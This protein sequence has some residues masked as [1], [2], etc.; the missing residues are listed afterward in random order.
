M[1]QTSTIEWTDATWNPVRGCTKISPGCKHCYAETFAERFRGV[2]GHPYEQGFDL[3][4]VPGKLDEPL[5]WKR[6][7]KIFVN[8][9]SDLFHPNVPD[10]Y[11]EQVCRVMMSAHWH[12]YQVLTKRAGRLNKLLNS[13]LKFATESSH[14]WWGVSVENTK[15]GAPRINEL[16]QTPAA[17]KFLSVEPLLEDLGEVDLS[18][19]HWMIVGGESGRGARPMREE[20]V[21][22][23][24]KQC[25][26]Q[27]VRFFFKQWGGPNKKATGRMLNGRTYDELPI[28]Q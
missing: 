9:M 2:L 1:S 16:R 7:R 23:L 8:S 12:K 15:H 22:S 5:N 6:P 4:T 25:R 19:I 26:Q 20:W 17:V 11:I 13:N 3:R 18:G 24:R 10:E 14:V 28:I 21:Q 27:K